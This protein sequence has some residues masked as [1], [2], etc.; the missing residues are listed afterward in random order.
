VRE[1]HNTSTIG[2]EYPEVDGGTDLVFLLEG[3]F[4]KRAKA[5]GGKEAL[6]ISS[7]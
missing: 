6:S 5:S 1:S 4:W 2:Q 7:V 3:W